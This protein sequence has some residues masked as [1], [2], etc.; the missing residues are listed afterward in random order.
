MLRAAL[1]AL[2]LLAPL[3]A[4]HPVPAREGSFL[5]ACAGAGVFSAGP[6]ADV[7]CGQGTELDTPGG[8]GNHTATFTWPGAADRTLR[9][10]LG[11]ADSPTAAPSRRTCV[12]GQGIAVVTLPA[13]ASDLR[14]HLDVSYR[15][16][17]ASPGTPRTPGLPY[18][19]ADAVEVHYALEHTH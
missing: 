12:E 7:L 19:F 18:A 6:S 8:E 17:S 1:L 5:V 2:V 14:L 13:D 10:C 3:G 4:G 16:S 9:V 15:L 11:A